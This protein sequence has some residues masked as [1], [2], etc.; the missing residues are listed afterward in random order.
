MSFQSR[1][2]IY[3]ANIENFT[4]KM[5]S[6]PTSQKISVVP[7]CSVS[8]SPLAWDCVCFNGEWHCPLSGSG[9]CLEKNIQSMYTK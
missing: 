9:V 3:N 8:S 1:P 6:L 5:R 4:N 2:A 7:F